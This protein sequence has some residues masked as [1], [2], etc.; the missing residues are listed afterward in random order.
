MQ[1]G[2]KS[3]WYDSK[4]LITVS[5]I[6]N[7]YPCARIPHVYSHIQQFHKADVNDARKTPGLHAFLKAVPLVRV[8]GG[9]SKE[10]CLALDTLTFLQHLCHCFKYCK[11]SDAMLYLLSAYRCTGIC[12]IVLYTSPHFRLTSTR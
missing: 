7:A 10:P 8:R 2:L 11:N 6:M 5:T 1:L 4:V 3:R 9:I 12:L